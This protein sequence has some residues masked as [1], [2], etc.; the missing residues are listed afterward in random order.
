MIDATNRFGNVAEI[1]LA[2]LNVSV[3]HD[4]FLQKLNIEIRYYHESHVFLFL[5]Q[6]I[7]LTRLTIP[8]QKVLRNN[9]VIILKTLLILFLKCDILYYVIM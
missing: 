9:I 3:F 2:S 5:N 7:R 6:E 8:S 4:K 1:N